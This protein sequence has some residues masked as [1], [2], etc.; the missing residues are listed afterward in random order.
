MRES[1]REL[2]AESSIMSPCHPTSGAHSLHSQDMASH[3]M[4]DDR[5]QRLEALELKIMEF[6]LIQ[7]ELDAVVI[8]QGA[9]IE[10]LKST[11]E[12]ALVRFEAA[13]NSAATDKNEPDTGHEPPPHY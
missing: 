2:A 6:E 9:E 12:M 8:R 5:N 13:G 7:N 3:N 10:Y 11:L 1:L 4:A